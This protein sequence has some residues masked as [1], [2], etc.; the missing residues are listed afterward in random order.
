MNVEF[1]GGHLLPL[2]KAVENS[3]IIVLITNHDISLDIDPAKIGP[4]MNNK[5]LLDT[6]N[7]LDHK[8]WKKAGFKI[9]VL[10][11]NKQK[12]WEKPNNKMK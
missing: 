4:L 3:D 7:H 1:E 11:N 10:G 5:Y 2:E 12:Y 8:T 9:K 6:R